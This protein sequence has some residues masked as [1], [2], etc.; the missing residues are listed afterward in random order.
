MPVLCG[1]DEGL[2]GCRAVILAETSSY[3]VDKR[4]FAVR[5]GAVHKKEGVRMSYP[6]ECVAGHSSQ[7]RDQF[8]VAPG[9]S[10]QECPPEWCWMRFVRGDGGNFRQ[11]GL[12]SMDRQLTCAQIDNAVGRVEQPR[13]AIPLIYRGRQ[14]TI[15]PGQSLDGCHSF[16]GR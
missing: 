9:H 15:R 10:S 3:G 4:S 8:D 1:R 2:D 5:A 11:I 16:G 12:G 7:E 6:C 13:I 14:A